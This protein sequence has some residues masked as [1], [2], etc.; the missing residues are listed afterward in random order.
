M[1]SEVCAFLYCSVL[2]LGRKINTRRKSQPDMESFLT[3]IIY[4]IFWSYETIMGSFK[5]I[6]IK[7][8]YPPRILDKHWCIY[9]CLQIPPR[10]NWFQYVCRVYTTAINFPCI[11]FLYIPMFYS[12][13]VSCL[14]FCICALMPLRHLRKLSEFSTVLDYIF[15]LVTYNLGYNARIVISEVYASFVLWAV[16]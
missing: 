2:S 6:K 13:N 7:C 8:F 10:E 1:F 16:M 12:Q 4:E 14:N 15:L 5:I 3:K 9:S 11:T